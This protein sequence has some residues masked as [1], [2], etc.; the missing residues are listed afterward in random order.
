MILP[1]QT[2]A[3][4]HIGCFEFFPALMRLKSKQNEKGPP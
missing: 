1:A 2:R 4:S 3:A